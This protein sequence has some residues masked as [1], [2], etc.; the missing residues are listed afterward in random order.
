MPNTAPARPSNGSSTMLPATPTMTRKITGSSARRVRP[1]GITIGVITCTGPF[2][3]MSKWLRD[4][5][6]AAS[7]RATDSAT[8]LVPADV[9]CSRA[10][11]KSPG[12]RSNPP[13]PWLPVPCTV[14]P[15]TSRTFSPPATCFAASMN[16][17]ALLT[18]HPLIDPCPGSRARATASLSQART[19]REGLRFLRR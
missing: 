6:S 12:L 17:C 1:R 14:R 18:P 8:I 3:P 10:V 9:P 19:E 13:S 11:G 16:C 15:T 2:G 5:C 7:S 4:R